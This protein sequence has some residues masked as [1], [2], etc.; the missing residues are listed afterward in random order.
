MVTKFGNCQLDGFVIKVI[1]VWEAQDPLRRGGRRGW[2]DLEKRNDPC[3]SATKLIIAKKIFF[4]ISFLSRN[5]PNVEQ[6]RGLKIVSEVNTLLNYVQKVVFYTHLVL[7]CYDSLESYER[8]LKI[9]PFS[10]LPSISFPI[11]VSL[12]ESRNKIEDFVKPIFLYN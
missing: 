8:K 7:T 9:G 10:L 4:H 3:R 2:M 12:S 1:K 11:L 5:F 6:K